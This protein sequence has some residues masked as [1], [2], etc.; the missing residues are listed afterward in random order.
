MRLV[1]KSARVGDFEV[2]RVLPQR[3]RRTVGPFCFLDHMGPHVAI[4]DAH[5]G[6][7]PHPHIGLATVTYLF[8]GDVLHRD[9]LGTVQRI[10]PGDVNWMTAGRG[11]VHAERTPPERYGEPLA[12]H[13]LQ[14]WVGLPADVEDGEPSFQHAPR[15]ALPRITLD[16]GE[17]AVV[18]GAWGDARS[19]IVLASETFY[20]VAT[21]EPGARLEVPDAW[22][23]RAA[24]VVEGRVRVDGEAEPVEPHTLVTLDDT[25]GARTLVAET[26]S[27]VA[28]LAGAPLEGPR[29]MVWNFVSSRP[30]HIEAAVERWDAG[31]FPAIDDP[32]PPVPMPAPR[33]VR[34]ARR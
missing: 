2:W 32:G 24:Y 6:V 33:P 13:G 19:P 30:E 29:H 5:S 25:P 16:R 31:A 9:S 18:L 10:R 7:G 34:I 17:L 3:A 22:P 1:G 26:A 27:R 4:G 28:V 8:E 21:L 14:L 12:L 23:A 20:G 11:I 15:S